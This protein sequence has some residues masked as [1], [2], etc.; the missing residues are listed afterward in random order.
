MIGIISL[1]IIVLLSAGCKD[2]LVS[3]TF[4][5]VKSF[6]FT[7]QSGFYFYQVDIT[8]DPDWQ[9]HKDKIHKIDAVGVEFYITST[10]AIDVTF[11]AY[12]DDWSGLGPVPS[13]VPATATQIIK[14][15]TVSPGKT[16]ITY[17]QSL[18]ILTGIDRLKALAKIG[19]FDYYGT[20]TGNT[21]TD[22]KID[23]AKV[24]VTVS[25]S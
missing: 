22:F 3:G 16:K 21:G 18:G 4:I 14:D 15:F 6:S 17:K 13:S 11:N 1:A 25:A 2:M 9:E 19:K 8:D 12:I 7:A 5:I 20:S 23:S 10:E 24:I